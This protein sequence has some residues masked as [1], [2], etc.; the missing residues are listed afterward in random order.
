MVDSAG[1]GFG[2]PELFP[3]YPQHQINA[4]AAVLAHFLEFPFFESLSMNF[5][6][7]L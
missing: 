2:S 5:V 7:M 1:A 3:I 4:G 6:K